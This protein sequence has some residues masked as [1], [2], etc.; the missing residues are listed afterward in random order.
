MKILDELFRY[1][2][3]LKRMS[4]ID[5]TRLCLLVSQ[6]EWEELKREMRALTPITKW[7]PDPEEERQMAL[8]RRLVCYG[9]EVRKR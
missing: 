2:Q 9:V 4:G 5:L 7:P 6:E 3:T 8:V 1:T